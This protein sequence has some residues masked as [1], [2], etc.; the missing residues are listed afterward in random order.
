[1]RSPAMCGSPS[2]TRRFPRDGWRSS[3][4]SPTG[5]PR[6]GSEC[7]ST[8]AMPTSRGMSATPSGNRRP[9]SSTCTLRTT[10]GTRTTTSFRGAGESPGPG[11][12]IRFAK[13][14]FRGR[15][16]WNFATTPGGTTRSTARSRR[17]FPSAAARSS[18]FPGKEDE[19]AGGRTG[20]RDNPFGVFPRPGPGGRGRGTGRGRFHT[21]VLPGPDGPGLPSPLPH[22]D[23]I[24]GRDP[25]GTGTPLRPRAPIPETGGR[26]RARDLPCRAGVQ[27]FVPG[28]RGRHA[29][30]GGRPVRPFAGRVPAPLRAVPGDSR[31]DPNGRDEGARRGG[32]PVPPRLRCGEVLRGNRLLLRERRPGIRRDLPVGNGGARHRGPVPAVPFGTGRAA[33]RARPP[34]LPQPEHHGDPGRRGG[35]GAAGGGARFGGGPDGE[36]L[37]RPLLPAAGFLRDAARQGG[38]RT[39]LRLPARSPRGSPADGGR[40]GLLFLPSRRFRPPEKRQGDRHVRKPGPQPREEFLPAV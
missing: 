25:A 39:R 16:P 6:S 29:A 13:P 3:W 17:F 26:P 5:I 11:R 8:W 37:L 32:D 19:P 22:H 24:P 15:S 23:G 2:K 36:R 1:M 14:D 7:A 20:N 21:A 30:G 9:G 28:G 40:S 33:A 35:S 18:V 38:R 4:T 10:K 27:G 12:S 34:R 31:P